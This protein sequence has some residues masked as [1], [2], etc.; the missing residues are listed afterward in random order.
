MNTKFY[1]SIRKSFL[2]NHTPF[3]LLSHFDDIFYTPT[4]TKKT[5]YNTMP[6]ANIYKNKSVSIWKVITN[7]YNSSG[8]VRLFEED[9]TSP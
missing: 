3:D 9:E 6:K 4:T 2:N 1:P 8:Y 5:K 7:R